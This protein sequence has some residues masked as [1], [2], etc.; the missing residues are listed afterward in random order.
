MGVS[1]IIPRFVVQTTGQRFLLNPG[2][3]GEEDNE[4]Y[5]RQADGQSFDISATK[6]GPQG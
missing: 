2:G 4:S 1:N 5:F 6:R 3:K